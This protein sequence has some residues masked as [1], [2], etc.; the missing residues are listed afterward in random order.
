MAVEID[1][2]DL[3]RLNSI[4]TAASKLLYSYDGLSDGTK[5]FLRKE[6]VGE[7]KLHLV[8]FERNISEVVDLIKNGEVK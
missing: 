3:R 1:R 5:E 7:T 4:L 2:K 6:S 8:N